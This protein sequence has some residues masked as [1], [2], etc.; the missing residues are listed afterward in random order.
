MIIC[1]GL[2]LKQIKNFLEGES[3]TLMRGYNKND[4]FDKETLKRKRSFW[5]N[6][7]LDKAKEKICNCKA[8]QR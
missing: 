5:K 1:K 4:L 6:E 2:S 3:P 8:N 7:V